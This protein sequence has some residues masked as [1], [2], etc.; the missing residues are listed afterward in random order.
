MA[1]EQCPAFSPWPWPRRQCLNRRLQT[2]N[3][4]LRDA[5]ESAVNWLVVTEER[6]PE[7][8]V[9]LGHRGTEV[10]GRWSRLSGV[11][12]LGRSSGPV[13]LSGRTCRTR[14]RS[15]AAQ[16]AGTRAV[17]RA[18]AREHAQTRGDSR[19]PGG[20]RGGGGDV[21]PPGV[22]RLEAQRRAR[23]G[24]AGSTLVR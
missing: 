7:R 9:W 18:K 5:S 15:G 21:L 13:Q 1:Q 3:N 10:G 4:G 2:M 22:R 23:S 11:W 24:R 8:E 14:P 20:P 12:P 17:P 16:T 6:A 19:P